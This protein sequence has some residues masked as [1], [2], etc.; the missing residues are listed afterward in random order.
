MIYIFD[1]TE[2]THKVFIPAIVFVAEIFI[3]LYKQKLLP[4]L[5]DLF[6]LAFDSDIINESEVPVIISGIP[7]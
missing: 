3:F 7:V 6:A 5:W 1:Q 2:V 4:P